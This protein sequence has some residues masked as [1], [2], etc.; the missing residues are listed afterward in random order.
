[1]KR[2]FKRRP[3]PAMIVA[4]IALAITLGG[5]SY[6]AIVI[7]RNSVGTVHLKNNAVTS[8]KVQNQSLRAIDFAP[9]QLLRGP[10]GPAGA[11]GAAG[12]AGPAGPAGPAG[13]SAAGGTLAFKIASSNDPVATTS[14][15]F[16]ELTSQTIAVPTGST[17]TLLVTF[18]AESACSGGT[19]SCAVRVMIDGVEAAPGGG[20]D[21]AFDSSDGGA[22]TASSWESHAIERF[23][24]GKAAG[25]HAI[26]V[27]YASTSSAT[28]HRLDD[29]TLSILA[30]KE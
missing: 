26:A 1:M 7:P 14:T 3:T 11:Q 18:S 10:A 9:G 28:T 21:I 16:V 13:A 17:A 4:C 2:V 8:L 29:W 27:Q 6:A 24:T 19:G 15:S 25:N 5:T 23:A 12:S 20:T 22:E 30:L